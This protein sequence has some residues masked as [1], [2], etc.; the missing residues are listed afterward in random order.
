[1]AVGVERI[2]LAMEKEGLSLL[3]AALEGVYIAAAPATMQNEGLLLLYRLREAGLRAEADYM[4]RSLKAMMKHAHRGKYRFVVILDE[5][6]G[7]RGTWKIRDMSRGE[8]R[9]C[10]YE[11]MLT[12][13]LSK[14]AEGEA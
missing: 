6:T 9:E 14:R 8:Q 2:L 10:A 5:E 13:L 7:E 3:P 4:G 1:M 11:E 12:Y